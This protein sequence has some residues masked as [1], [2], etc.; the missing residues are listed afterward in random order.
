MY[1]K[2]REMIEKEIDGMVSRELTGHS[3]ECIYKMIDIIKDSYEI[4]TMKDKLR[5]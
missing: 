2:L 3:L 5:M 4:E 1:E